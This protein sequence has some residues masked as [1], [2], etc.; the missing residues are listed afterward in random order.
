MDELIV[1]Q[2]NPGVADTA[3]PVGAE[4]Q[5]IARLQRFTLDQRR[6]DIDHFAGRTRQLHAEFF[7]EQV[8]D[9][10]AAIESRLYR[11]AAV[12]V[13]G[14]NQRQAMGQDAVG[15]LGKFVGFVAGKID[16]RF[17]CAFIKKNRMRGCLGLRHCSGRRRL[18]H[19]AGASGQNQSECERHERCEVFEHGHN[20]S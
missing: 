10:A 3:T 9:E 18:R 12:A 19:M 11:A 8:T 2:I 5:Q 6:I 4:E 16:V 7:L 14:A 1:T 20:V 13:T 15:Q 17:G